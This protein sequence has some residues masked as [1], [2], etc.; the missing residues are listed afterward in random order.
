[1]GGAAGQSYLQDEVTTLRERRARD[2]IPYP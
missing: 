2:R 1:M